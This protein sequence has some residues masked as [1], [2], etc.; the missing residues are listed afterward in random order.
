MLQIGQFLYLALLRSNWF[1]CANL[2]SPVIVYN[3]HLLMVSKIFPFV[4]V[5]SCFTWNINTILIEICVV[6]FLMYWW[7]NKEIYRCWSEKTWHSWT[8]SFELK[9]SPISLSLKVVVTFNSDYRTT[10][11]TWALHFA[12]IMLILYK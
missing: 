5:S 12:P 8:L 7:R 6:I 1:K 9:T 11:K 3:F 10:E 2:F 4:G